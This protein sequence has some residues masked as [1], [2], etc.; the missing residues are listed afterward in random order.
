MALASPFSAL[1][2]FILPFRAAI[3]VEPRPEIHKSALEAR[4]EE[5]RDEVVTGH[6]NSVLF[7]SFTPQGVLQDAERDCTQLTHRS[8]MAAWAEKT[9][10]QKGMR[11]DPDKV[12][13]H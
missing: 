6:E 1:N 4:S 13:R 5:T 12:C 7:L 2:P 10:Q 11:R 3:S 9:L 8:G